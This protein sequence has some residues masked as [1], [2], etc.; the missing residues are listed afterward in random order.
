MFDFTSSAEATIL[1][2]GS[3]NRSTTSRNRKNVLEV[4]SG[5]NSCVPLSK[6]IAAARHG[7]T[8][9]EPCRI[10]LLS[11]DLIIHPLTSRILTKNLI[12]LSI[13]FNN[14]IKL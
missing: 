14:R 6:H 2:M 1:F 10:K 7:E 8:N 5:L 13:Y 3:L 4:I 12:L 11:N 9:P